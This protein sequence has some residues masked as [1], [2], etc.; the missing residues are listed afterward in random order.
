MIAGLSITYSVECIF[1]WQNLKIHLQIR[2]W[3]KWPHGLVQEIKPEN[4]RALEEPLRRS[5]SKSWRFYFYSHFFWSHYGNS[6][7]SIGKSVQ[8]THIRMRPTGHRSEVKLLK[9]LPHR[10]QS[11]SHDM[12]TKGQTRE[13]YSIRALLVTKDIPQSHVQVL[14]GLARYDVSLFFGNSTCLD[15]QSYPGVAGASQ[16]R[17]GLTEG[18]GHCG[19]AC[20][21]FPQS[22][23][24]LLFKSYWSSYLNNMRKKHWIKHIM[25]VKY[26]G[27]ARPVQE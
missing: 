14:L 8:T 2:D 18:Q 23:T 19:Q 24:G 25:S 16:V 10:V 12:D 4:L 13:K 27:F 22:S 6:P 15:L 26:T 9:I 1:D 17:W 21:H 3:G 11:G 7:L 20:N 5:S